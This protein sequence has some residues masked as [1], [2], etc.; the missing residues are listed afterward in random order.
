VNTERS[1][2]ELVHVYLKGAQN[3]RARGTQAG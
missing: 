3:L 2:E 1:K